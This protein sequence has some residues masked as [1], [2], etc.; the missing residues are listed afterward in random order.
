MTKP[1]D[2]KFYVEIKVFFCILNYAYDY[3]IDNCVS[4]KCC[5]ILGHKTLRITPCDCCHPMKIM[6]FL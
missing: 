2:R 1:I 3:V 6:D 5:V 4:H